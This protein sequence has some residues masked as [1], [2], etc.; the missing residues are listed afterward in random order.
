MEKNTK[1][2]APIT[3]RVQANAKRKAWTNYFLKQS[4]YRF[5]HM[6]R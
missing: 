1:H 2:F 3:T 6:F 4:V 5:E